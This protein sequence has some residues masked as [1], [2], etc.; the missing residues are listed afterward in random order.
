LA[1]VCAADISVA[2]KSH[3]SSTDEEGIVFVAE[4]LEEGEP[5]FEE[6]EDL[7]IR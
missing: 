5:D 1:G 7:Q 3:N 6:T 4:D 2:R